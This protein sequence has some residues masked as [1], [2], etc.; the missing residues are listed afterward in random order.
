M[1]DKEFFIIVCV[2]P[3]LDDIKD[4]NMKR[5]YLVSLL[6]NEFDSVPQKYVKEYRIL[7]LKHHKFFKGYV[8]V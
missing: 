1:T 7:K 2:I 3:I 5:Y 6:N 4:V 8:S